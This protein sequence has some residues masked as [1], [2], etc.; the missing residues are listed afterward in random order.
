MKSP[1]IITLLSIL[2]MS[3]LSCK[4]DVKD[5]RTD[6]VQTIPIS[7]TTRLRLEENVKERVVDQKKNKS[8]KKKASIKK[9][10]KKNSAVLHIPG[11]FETTENSF[12]KKYVKDYE[13]YVTNYKKAVNAKDM[14]SFLKLSKAR[15]KSKVLNGYWIYFQ[16]QIKD[17]LVK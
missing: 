12:S 15:R 4:K 11:T 17:R 2:M 7:D 10:S 3:F 14:D 8:E 9:D 13:E 1:L 5:E 6:T 16:V